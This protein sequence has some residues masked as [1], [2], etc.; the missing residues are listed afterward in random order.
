MA[1]FDPDAY[2][3][4]KSSA[5][6]FDP[7]AYLR[8]NGALGTAQTLAASTTIQAPN[9]APTALQTAGTV[10]K[11]VGLGL[12]HTAS[13]VGLGLLDA[14]LHPIQ[15]MRG[16]GLGV[17]SQMSG[18]A[19]SY[20][21]PGAPGYV[22]PVAAAK[23]SQD[24]ANMAQT[25]QEKRGVTLG[26]IGA[27]WG[28]GE[29]KPITAAAGAATQ[30][31]GNVAEKTFTDALVG[32]LG[33]LK[34]LAKKLGG[35]MSDAKDALAGIIQ[36][37]NLSDV[38]GFGS[39]Q[40]KADALASGKTAQADQLVNKFAMDNP[41]GA[42]YDISKDIF[43]DIRG[44][45]GDYVR[46]GE[47]KQ[48][49]VV[50]DNIQESVLDR[51]QQNG[52]GSGRTVPIDQLVE[53]KRSL[54]PRFANK[55]IADDPVKEKMYETAYLKMMD[56]INEKVP[57]AGALNKE[58]RDIWLA[59]DAMEEA[60]WRNDKLT[61]TIFG[62]AIGAAGAAGIVTHPQLAIPL[63]AAAAGTEL[64]RRGVTQG[65]ALSAGIA[66]SRGMQ[67]LGK[68]GKSIAELGQ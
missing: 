61:N 12:L 67:W 60:A 3:A 19:P 32:E 9:P 33:L 62:T 21:T 45:I 13:D 29:S 5:A 11:G 22:D 15:T 47:E 16:I 31:A 25:P 65:R 51:L 36:K 39:A 7:D 34:P 54:N 24:V 30:A 23:Q 64:A 43:K 26:Q 68:Q 57:E 59:K 49:L 28:A 2:I 56:A 8:E 44:N 66:A 10:A 55:S 50:L 17:M 20:V 63:A 18:S 40:A 52:Y 4:A 37:Y 35:T 42:K 46:P 58:A 27:T 41:T 6:T 1:D 53:V 38:R 14:P 48:A